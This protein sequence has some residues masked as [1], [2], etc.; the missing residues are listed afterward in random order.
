MFNPDRDIDFHAVLWVRADGNI[1]F[2]PLPLSDHDFAHLTKLGKLAWIVITNSDH[3]R[4]A[5]ALA[6]RT[7]AKLAGPRGE[8]GSFP[9]ACDRWLDGGD[10][11]VDGLE[12]FALEGSKTAGELALLVE[13]HTLIFFFSDNGGPTMA[14][15][16]VNGSSNAPLRGSKRQTWEGG[17]RVPFIIRWKGH[18]AEGRVDDRPVIQLDVLPTALA[19]AGVTA[20]REQLDGVNLF[21]YLTD[22]L[23][24]SPHQA[25]YWRLGGM[26]AVR[27]GNWKLVKTRDGPLVDVDPERLSD[28]ST[29]ELYNLA[30]DLGET[31]NLA[32]TH[33]EVAKELA[34]LWQRW[35]GQLASPLWPPRARPPR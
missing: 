22:S 5:A 8:Q 33:P 7:G 12:V 6:A 28:L 23:A 29:A 13:E 15:T 35:N 4:D 27:K 31:R 30:D 24:A 34:D 19:A 17:I 26:M 1:A 32:S 25:L 14:T 11:L 2:D 18:L 10:Q 21:P 9:L 3:V 20:P 16:T